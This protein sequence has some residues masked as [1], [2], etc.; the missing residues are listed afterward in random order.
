MYKEQI[1]DFCAYLL[2][3]KNY[4]LNTIK[5]YKEDLF[6]FCKYYYEQRGKYPKDRKSVV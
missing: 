1:N 2:K 6:A 5:A 3:E 4:S